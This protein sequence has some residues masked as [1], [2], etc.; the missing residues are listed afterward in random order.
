MRLL[1]L[2]LVSW[3]KQ[4]GWYNSGHAWLLVSRLFPLTVTISASEGCPFDCCFLFSAWPWSAFGSSSPGGPFPHKH[5][6]RQSRSLHNTQS[7]STPSR[8]L[9]CTC[10][11]SSFSLQSASSHPLLPHPCSAS[12]SAR[13]TSTR[14]ERPPMRTRCPSPRRTSRARSYGRRCSPAWR[15][16]RRPRS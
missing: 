12:T 2:A 3:R 5:R 1:S 14:M 13:S 8:L 15:T 9:P 6:L 4:H 11:P 7:R 16:A 10:F